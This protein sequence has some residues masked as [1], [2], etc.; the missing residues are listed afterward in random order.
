MSLIR[1]RSK[2][3][4]PIISNESFAQR[5]WLK[6]RGKDS[7]LRFSDDMIKKLQNYF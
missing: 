6:R 1:S 4:T 2:I 7:M 3:S 5:Q